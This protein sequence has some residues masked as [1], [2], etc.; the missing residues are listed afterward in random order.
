MDLILGINQINQRGNLFFDEQSDFSDKKN[1]L[2]KNP[3]FVISRK[4]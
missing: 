4:N 1:N 3:F 2:E